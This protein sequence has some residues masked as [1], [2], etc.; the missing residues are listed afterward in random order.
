[1]PSKLIWKTLCTPKH[2]SNKRRCNNKQH[3]WMQI[4]ASPTPNLHTT[5]KII[6]RFTLIIADIKNRGSTRNTKPH[7][8][9]CIF[10]SVNGG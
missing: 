6:S 7:K 9:I 10:N 3:G 4:I 1:M 5:L 2:V 8:I